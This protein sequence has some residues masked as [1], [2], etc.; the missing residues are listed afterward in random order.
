M[1]G[2]PEHREY[3]WE[4]RY[5]T[6]DWLDQLPTSG[7]FGSIPP[8][9]AE[10]VLDEIRDVVDAYGGAFTMTYTTV[11]VTAERSPSP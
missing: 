8:D 11:L 9:T 10:V 3:P 4:Q 5:T 6:A 2:E 7:F 1:F